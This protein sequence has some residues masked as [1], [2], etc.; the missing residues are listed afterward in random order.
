MT[1]RPVLPVA[2]DA[3]VL[4]GGAGARLG[5]VSK[6]E[7]AVAG[8]AMLDHVLDATRAAVRVVVVGDATLARPGVVTTLED[9]PLGGPVA[10]IAAGL[11]ALAPPAAAHVLVLACDMPF[12]A[13]A[14]PD[15][16]AAAAAAPEA[17]EVAVA[18]DDGRPQHLLAVYRRDVLEAALDRL[19]D[20]GGVRDRSV[21]SLVAG[22]DA[23]T[24]P[25]RRGAAL[26][27]DTWESV[28]ELEHLAAGGGPVGS[29]HQPV[30]PELHRWVAVLVEELDVDASAVDV[31]AVLDLAREAAN[32]VARPA[33]PLT[34]F[35]VGY[36]VAARGGDRAAF[37][38]VSARVTAL[39][40][41]WAARKEAP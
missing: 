38:A 2:H 21:R 40:Q 11:A 25:D 41:E 4:A 34:G 15:L 16:L 30:G 36:A 22:L 13:R 26:D 35:L 23:V 6:A 31:E 29:T 19:R 20:D 39:A 1:V 28:A 10:G 37:E 33:V 18:D 9:P 27:G 8:R 3:L 32:G 5:G 24:V 14:V 12:A 17:P 7:V